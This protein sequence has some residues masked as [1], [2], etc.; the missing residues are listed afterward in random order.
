[1][2]LNSIRVMCGNNVSALRAFFVWNPLPGPDGPGKGCFGPFGPAS[3]RIRN[4]TFNA[5][6]RQLPDGQPGEGAWPDAVDVRWQLSRWAGWLWD[7]GRCDGCPGLHDGLR[8]RVACEDFHGGIVAIAGVEAI[9]NAAEGNSAK[10]T[11]IFFARK[12]GRT[13]R[14]YRVSRP[15]VV[16][17][18]A[19]IDT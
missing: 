17:S 4:K 14:R 3:Q 7:T 15:F 6:N 13:H 8:S 9:L 16:C 2:R 19:G 11:L 12:S 5:S 10:H 1:M 18:A